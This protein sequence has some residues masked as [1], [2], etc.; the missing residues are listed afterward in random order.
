MKDQK[1]FNI[2]I[3]DDKSG[4]EDEIQKLKSERVIE[5]IWE[6]DFTVWSNS[7]DEISNRL[8]WLQSPDASLIMLR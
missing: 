2:F 4:I 1:T 8:G 5:R 3:G 6:K 7:P